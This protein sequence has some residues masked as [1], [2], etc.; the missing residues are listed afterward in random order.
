MIN[1]QLDPEPAVTWST[2]GCWERVQFVLAVLIVM[3]IVGTAVFGD[4]PT[5]GRYKSGHELMVAIHQEY[6]RIPPPAGATLAELASLGTL[7]GL[8][9]WLSQRYT[10]SLSKAEVMRNYAQRLHENGWIED[11]GNSNGRY[12]KNGLSASIYFVEPKKPVGGLEY[13][14]TIANING[15]SGDCVNGKPNH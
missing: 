13:Y 4:K 5:Y 12:C 1:L 3:L 7:R 11:V 15:G 9:G 14:F 6:D 2:M 8:S 10:T